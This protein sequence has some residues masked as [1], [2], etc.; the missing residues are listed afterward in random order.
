[1][2]K[3]KGSWATAAVAIAEAATSMGGVWLKRRFT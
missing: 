3:L 2:A 1:M